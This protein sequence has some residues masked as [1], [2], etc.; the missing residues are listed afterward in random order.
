MKT[1]EERGNY[2]MLFCA[3]LICFCMWL[4]FLYRCGSRL[5]C[6]NLLVAP[7]YLWN[8]FSFIHYTFM[9]ILRLKEKRKIMDIVWRMKEFCIRCPIHNDF[10]TQAGERF[11]FCEVCVRVSQFLEQQEIIKSWFILTAWSESA[12]RV[13]QVLSCG[14]YFWRSFWACLSPPIDW[15]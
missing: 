9:C 7:E 14:E 2:G 8:R 3:L 5:H 1:W 6:V 10:K 15:K 13:D 4:P 12:V 11:S